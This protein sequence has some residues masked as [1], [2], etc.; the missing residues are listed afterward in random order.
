[1]WSSLQDA[2]A[3]AATAVAAAPIGRAAWE[4]VLAAWRAAHIFAAFF[5]IS[6]YVAASPG[7]CLLQQ[8][9][10]GGKRSE[11]DM[12]YTLRAVS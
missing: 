9:G 7:S 8:N 5:E 3:L 6:P 1:M 4:R 2:T 10:T 11:G 12:L